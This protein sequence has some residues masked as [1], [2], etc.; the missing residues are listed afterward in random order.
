ML[1]QHEALRKGIKGAVL[2][3]S[4]VDRLLPYKRNATS[5][6]CGARQALL[7]LLCMQDV[8]RGAKT[9]HADSSGN[10]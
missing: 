3:R 10:I 9:Q 2:T 6:A 1:Q 7:E 5:P 4:L 8:D